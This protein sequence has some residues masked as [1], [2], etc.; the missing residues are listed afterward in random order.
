MKKEFEG[1]SVNGKTF[2]DILNSPTDLSGF[3]NEHSAIKNRK[4]DRPQTELKISPN[5]K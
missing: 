3:V 1:K 4:I 5:I 2:E